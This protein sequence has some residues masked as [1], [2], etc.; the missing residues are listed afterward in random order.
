M[1][2]NNYVNLELWAERA[3]RVTAHALFMAGSIYIAAHPEWAV[4]APV[5]QYLGQAIDTAR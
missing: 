5:L 4:Y 2:E 1:E 3:L